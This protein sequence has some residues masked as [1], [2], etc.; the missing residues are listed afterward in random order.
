M[1]NDEPTKEELDIMKSICAKYNV[2][3]NDISNMIYLLHTNR[4]MPTPKT[5]NILR[6]IADSIES[7]IGN[8]IKGI[9]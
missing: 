2:D 7:D 6:A 9:H 1:N 3:S 5:A 8:D 4:W